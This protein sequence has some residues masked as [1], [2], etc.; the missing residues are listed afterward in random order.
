MER[1]KRY[2]DEIA[3]PDELHKRLKT[4]EKLCRERSKRSGRRWAASLLRHRRILA[5]TVLACLILGL[6]ILSAVEPGGGR[7]TDFAERFPAAGAGE[8][9]PE[10][11][12]EDIAEGGAAGPEEEGA[13]AEPT[14]FERCLPQIKAGDFS[15]WER[16][17]PAGDLLMEAEGSWAQGTK[18]IF[19]T[20]KSLADLEGDIA[21]ETKVDPL[22]G[23]IRAILVREGCR[24]EYVFSGLTEEEAGDILA[25]LR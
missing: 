1:Y 11:G 24:I 8:A 18:N 17:A 6:A 9:R 5:S 25:T 21:E 15:G 12:I 23:K 22:T 14:D 4:P 10:A 3:V 19:V 13:E 7:E 16:S 20:V 2:M